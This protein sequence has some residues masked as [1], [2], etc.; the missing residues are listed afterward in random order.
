MTEKDMSLLEEPGVD[1]G[2][3]T[4]HT[5]TITETDIELFAQV[6]G[7]CNPEKHLYQP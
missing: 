5:K 7:D 2:Y 4:T 1:I 6:S 3:K